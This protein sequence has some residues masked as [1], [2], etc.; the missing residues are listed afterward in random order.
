MKKIFGKAMIMAAGF[1]LAACSTTRQEAATMLVNG[2][3][4]VNS[5]IT[6]LKM[7]MLCEPICAGPAG[8]KQVRLHMPTQ[9]P[10]VQ[11]NRRSEKG[12]EVYPVELCCRGERG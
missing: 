2:T 11:K 4:I 12:R 5:S 1:V 3:E 7:E 6:L 8:G 9:N 10:C